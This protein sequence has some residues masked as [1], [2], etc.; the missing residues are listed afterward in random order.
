MKKIILLILV[1]TFVLSASSKVSALNVAPLF[2][3]EVTPDNSGKDAQYRIYGSICEYSNVKAL[4]LYFRA[5]TGFHFSWVSSGTVLVNGI[6]AIGASFKKLPDGTVEVTI[7][8]SRYLNEGDPLEILFKEEAGLIN[9]I[10]PATCYFMRIVFVDSKGVELGTASS[11]RY[12]IGLSAVSNSSVT[13]EPQVRG[14]NAEYSVFFITGVKGSLKANL[15]EIRIKFPPGTIFPSL[16]VS[17]KVL[18]NGKLS[19]TIYRDSE[20]PYVMRVFSSFDIPARTPVGVL[21]KKEFG[22]KNTL[23]PGTYKI[24]VSTYTEPDWDESDPFVIVEPQVKDLLIK[25]SKDTILAYTSMII[26]FKTSQIGFL[27][28]SNKIYVSFPVEFEVPLTFPDSAIT[29]NGTNAYAEEL[30]NTVIITSPISIL[31]N[32]DVEIVINEEAKI[33]NPLKTGEYTINLHTDTDTSKSQ[34]AITIKESTIQNVNTQLLYSGTGTVNSFNISFVTGPAYTLIRSV[35]FVKIEFPEGFEIPEN[36]PLSAVLVDDTN[37]TS[38]IKEGNIL[39]TFVPFDIPSNSTVTVK[40]SEEAQVKNPV[41]TGIY[42]LKV[43]TSKEITSVES[44]PINIIP[45]PVVELTINPAVPDGSNGI[46]RKNPSILLSTSNGKEV[47][48]KIDDK[49]FALFTVQFSIPEG[50]H[51]VYAYAVDSNGNKGDVINRIFTVDNTPPKVLFDGGIGNIYTNNTNAIV[52]GK[53]SEVCVLQVAGIIVDVKSDL[54]FSVSLNVY[55]GM[56]VPIF[57]RDLAGNSISILITAHVDS[58]PPVIELVNPKSENFDTAEQSIILEF[59]VNKQ[60][61]VTVNSNMIESINGTYLFTADL[62]DGENGFAIVARDLAGN[63]ATE[64]ITI[65]RVNEVVIKLVIGD[66]TAYIGSST[67]MLDAPP[68]IEKGFT[69]VPLRFISEA[70]GASVDWNDALKVITIN[71]RTLTIQLQVGSNVVLVGTEFKKLDVPPKIVNGRTFV[72]IRFI[73]ETFGAEVGWDGATKTVTIVY[74][75]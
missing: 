23:T 42:S 63:E 30:S 5:D 55:D 53:V 61:T 73:S 71:Y 17:S 13:I 60:G 64:N 33:K 1:F 27:E 56:P 32:D 11:E 15:E 14:V 58:T 12:R 9:P 68:F 67:S 38:I 37:P 51:T 57:M 62:V 39:L 24:F 20:D 4:K 75:L 31:N 47:Y 50:E 36:I 16:L 35:D 70:F 26:N 25:I 10:T 66:T 44:S 41:N 19:S 7:N 6:S 59:K 8:L 40:I 29:V 54:T 46:Y 28:K 34:F 45:L 69:L 18:I 74:K 22:I 3:I 21:F 43:S 49:D 48:Y 72:P 2:K 65:K 52:N